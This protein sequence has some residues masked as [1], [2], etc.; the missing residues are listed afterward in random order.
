MATPTTAEVASYQ[1]DGYV[2]PS[3]RLAEGKVSRLRETLDRLIADN[4]GVRPRRL[5]S[6]ETRATALPL[7]KLHANAET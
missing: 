1:R 7:P 2:V 6:L 3:F 4:P 5:D